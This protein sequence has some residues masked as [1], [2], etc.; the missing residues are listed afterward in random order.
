MPFRVARVLL[1]PSPSTK[2]VSLNGFGAACIEASLEGMSD[3]QWL[4]WLVFDLQLAE[5]PTALPT[6]AQDRLWTAWIEAQCV[7]GQ[8]R[9]VAQR[10][11]VAA[12][13]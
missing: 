9:V 12:V 11:A 7:I 2:D 3:D 6:T 4:V 10:S 8:C 1:S 5:G 13:P